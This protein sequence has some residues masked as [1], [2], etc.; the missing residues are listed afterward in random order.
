MP[1]EVVI[2]ARVS[3]TKQLDEGNGLE[4]QVHAGK[5][6]AKF[7]GWKVIDVFREPGI[8]GA[9][10]KRPEME[11]MISF[12]RGRHRQN[13]ETIIVVDDLKRFSRDI[14]GYLGLKELVHSCGARLASPKFTFNDSPEGEFLELLTVMTGQLERK[15]NRRQVIDRMRSRVEQGY[16]PFPV[17]PPGLKFV[18]EPGHGK[19]MRRQ[20]P[21]ASIYAEALEGFASG[22]FSNQA[23]IREFLVRKLGRPLTIQTARNTLDR[24]LLYAG[25]VEYLK[26]GVTRRQGQHDALI[27][28]ETHNKIQD[29]LHGYIRRHVRKDE[30]ED[31]PLR[32]HVRCAACQKRLRGA[33]CTGNGGRYAKYWCANRD[34]EFY[35]ST[36]RRDDIEGDF[37]KLLQELKPQQRTL[38]AVERRLLRRWNK[39]L[40]EVEEYRSSIGREAKA[41]TAQVNELVDHTVGAKNKTVRKAFEKR[42]EELELKREALEEKLTNFQPDD[43]DYQT[44][45]KEV[46]NFIKNP[47]QR[48]LEGTLSEQ[49]QVLDIC[50][51]QDVAYHPKHGYQTMNL[52]PTFAIIT[53]FTDPK[54][55]G[56]GHGGS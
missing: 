28:L 33:W 35:C 29:R 14:G 48:W 41:I 26:W 34:C 40:A 5:Q 4:S 11:K 20:E 3:S 31:F 1:S 43:F 45:L 24:A 42:V 50:F 13:K 27:S 2:Y 25:Q 18:R 9:V 16:W 22:R 38:V 21:E 30:N 15:Q 53:G 23:A 36:I 52:S 44:A 8:S 51:S 32:G 37:R 56:S 49:H 39:K 55:K 17:P 54:V 6:Y 46:V 7:N 19:V 47:H 12:L 10:S